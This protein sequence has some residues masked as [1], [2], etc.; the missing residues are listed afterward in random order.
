MFQPLKIPDITKYAHQNLLQEDGADGPV[1]ALKE[2]LQAAERSGLVEYSLGGHKCQRP[3]DVQQ[4]RAD[5]RFEISPD[6]DNE[7]LWRPNAFQTRSLKASNIASHFSFTSLNE[8]PLVMAP[9]F[10]IF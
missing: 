2:A 9:C 8:S 3:S 10:K 1:T 6:L 5:D 4:G 7:L